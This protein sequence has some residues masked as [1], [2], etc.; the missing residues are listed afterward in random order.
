MKMNEKTIYGQRKLVP[1]NLTR[2]IYTS[3]TGKGR[4]KNIKAL[5]TTQDMSKGG[6]RGQS[7]MF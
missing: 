7:P 3:S 4:F 6:F 1:D 2:E 5:N